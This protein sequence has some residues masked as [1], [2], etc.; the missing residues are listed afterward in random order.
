V[1]NDERFARGVREF[2][3]GRFFEAHEVWEDLW[4]EYREADRLF[5]QGLIQIAAGLYHAQTKNWKGSSSQLSKGIEKL[6]SFQPTHHQID[7]GSLLSGA[8]EFLQWTRLT[9]AGDVRSVDPP[10]YPHLATNLNSD[11]HLISHP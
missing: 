8:G 9:M 1:V 5:I 3:E 11:H 6:K 2:N 7:V 4:H 10:G